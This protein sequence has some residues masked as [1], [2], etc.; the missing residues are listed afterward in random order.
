[1]TIAEGILATEGASAS[2]ETRLNVAD[3]N[4]QVGEVL[5]RNGARAEG[6]AKLKKALGIYRELRKDELASALDEEVRKP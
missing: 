6:V 5:L 4:A 2:E 1:M 3:T